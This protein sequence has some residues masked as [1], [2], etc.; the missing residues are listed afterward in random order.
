MTD[1]FALIYSSRFSDYSYGECHPFKVDRYRLTYELMQQYQL[2]TPSNVKQVECPV[3]SEEML[4]DFHRQD[5]LDTLKLFSMDDEVHANFFYG[6]GDIE[7][8]VFKGLYDW[9]RLMCGGTIEAVRQ[10]VEEGCRASFSMAGGWH[11]AHSARAS[12]F[13]YL[14]DAVVAIAQLLKQG[15]RVVYVDIDA[16]HGDGVQQAFYDNDQ[17]LTISIHENGKDFYP[18]SGFVDEVG[19]G[20]G[21]GYSVNIPLVPHSD[22][23]IFEQAFTRTILPLIKGFAPDVLVTQ[24]GADPLRTDPLTRLECTTAFMEYAGRGFLETAIPWVAI[25]GGGY[26]RLNVARAW[27]LLWSTM[28]GLPVADEIPAPFRKTMLSLDEPCDWLRDPPH[29]AAPDDFSR[30]QQSLDKNISIIERQ[31]FPLLNLSPRG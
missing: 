3:A 28:I 6:L 11:H 16:H 30:A 25:G 21:Y 5:Y 31:I 10:V 17:V 18:Y 27:T 29:M 9:S 24:M 12:G 15:K 19:T 2:L 23:L 8:P 4:R 14:N 26:D 13:S 7:N 20:Q 22:D 1:Q